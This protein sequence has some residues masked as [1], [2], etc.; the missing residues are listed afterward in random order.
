MRRVGDRALCPLDGVSY[1]LRTPDLYDA[2]RVRRLLS[3]QGVRRPG[4]GEF[5]AAA[6]K[7]I[8]EVGRQAGDEAEGEAQRA[9]LERWYEL[10]RPIAEDD[11]DEPDPM[12]RAELLI[13]READRQRDLIAIYPDA[14]AIEATLERH[15]PPYAELVG[16]RNYYDDVS[17]IEIVR[18]LLEDIDGAP[19]PRDADGLL[20][21]AAY[22]AL[23]RTHKMPL[24]TFAFR[25]LA[26][27]E[28]QRKN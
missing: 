17:R 28:A 6:F 2:A 25:Q 22:R 16:D 14:S 12:K 11:I 18:L 4:E 9:L 13:A 24:A 10:L 21:E 19:L 3:R 26:P 20:T 15:W 23:P 7:G 5:R 1:G 27:D 8:V